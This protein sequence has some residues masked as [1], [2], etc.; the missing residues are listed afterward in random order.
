MIRRFLL[1]LLTALPSLADDVPPFPFQDTAVA[2]GSKA[3]LTFHCLQGFS[4]STFAIPTLIVH[5]AQPGPRLAITAGIHGDELNGMEIAR[6]LY[7]Q[8]DP[9]LLRGT[10]VILPVINYQG[11]LTGNRYLPDRRDL[12][13]FFP[14]DPEGSTA[15]ML[16]H[17]VFHQ[18]IVGSDALI[19]LHCA[20]DRRSNLPQIRADY[21]DAQAVS[22]ACHFGIGVV[23]QGAGPPGS[24]RRAASEA[25]IPAIIYETGSPHL[26]EEKEI[27]LG[28]EGVQNVM[29]SLGMLPSAGKT[30]PASEVYHLTSWLRTP[31]EAGGNFLPRLK[32]GDR[33]EK[34]QVLGEV[35]DPL[36]GQSTVIQAPAAGRIIGL[37]HPTVVFP[38]EALVHLGLAYTQGPS[39]PPH[40]EAD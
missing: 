6:R 18:A 37:S 22:L 34:G 24:L 39:H 16:A 11:Y 23:V 33:V 5:G 19:D 8:V 10:L 35:I 28:L 30:V 12:N 3:R 14:G 29:R 15:S 38:G 20:S 26:F 9:T 4:S 31:R 27:A 36:S 2:A 1:F 13:R 32:L 7:E 21:E 17:R 40:E 25:G